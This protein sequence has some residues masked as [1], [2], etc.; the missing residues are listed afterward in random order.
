MGQYDKSC[1]GLELLISLH[2]GEFLVNCPKAYRISHNS[3]GG[4]DINEWLEEDKGIN[5]IQASGMEVD[6]PEASCQ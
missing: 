1:H 5:H 4:G 6:K 3:H 2:L